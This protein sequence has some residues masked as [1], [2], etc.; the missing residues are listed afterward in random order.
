MPESLN[1]LQQ[2]IAILE[3]EYKTIRDETHAGHNTA[4]RIGKAFLDLLYLLEVYDGLFISKA[5]DD[6]THYEVRFLAGL[7][8]DM[9]VKSPDWRLGEWLKDPKGRDVNNGKGFDIWKNAVDMWNIEIDY[10]T[11]RQL[12][13]CRELYTQSAHIDE[14]TNQTLFKVGLQT[15][16]NIL[17]GYY[18]EGVQGGIITPDGHVEINTL[19]SRGLAK[20]QELFVVNDATFGGNL[21]SIEFISSFLGG[22]GWAIQKKKRIN[23]LGVEEEYY[24]LEIDNVTIRETLRVYELVVSQLRGEFDNYVFAAMMEVHHYDK[25]TGKVWLTTEGGRIKGVAFRK[26][27]YIKCQQYLP[28]N[29]VVSGGNGYITKSYELIVTNSGTG[30]ETDENGDRLDWITFKNFV[31]SMETEDGGTSEVE[32][33]AAIRTRTA[34]LLRNFDSEGISV[35][36]GSLTFDYLS[37][38]VYEASEQFSGNSAYGLPL[39]FKKSLFPNVIDPYGTDTNSR[40]FE[41]MAGWL[42]ASALTEIFPGKR[43]ELLKIGYNMGPDKG[44]YIYKYTFESDPNVGRLVASAICAAMRGLLKP[45]LSTMRSEQHAPA[46]NYKIST[47]RDAS[48][49]TYKD[50]YYVDLPQFMPTAPG[51]YLDRYANRAPV[52]GVPYNAYD[53]A[54]HNLQ[55]DVDVH[56]KVVSDYNLDNPAYRQATVQAIANKESTVNHVFG[57]NRSGGGYTFHPVFGADTIGKEI[58]T[59]GS[60][61][62]A[63]EKIG[64]IGSRSRSPLQDG[65][66]YGRKRPGQGD[67]DGSSPA[68]ASGVLVNLDIE[69]SDGTPTGYTDAAAWDRSQR[70]DVFANSYPSGHSSTTFAGALFLIETMPMRADLILKA[71]NQYATDRQITRYHWLSDT[72]IGRLS[73]AAIM[74]VVRGSSDYAS[75]LSDAR[76]EVGEADNTTVAVITTETDERTAEELIAKGD[77]FVRI[78]NETDPER[79]GLMQI[80]TVGPNTPY[81]DVYYGMKTNPN[82]ALKMRTGNLSGVRTDL[83]GWLEDFGAY[84]PNVYAV[85]KIFNRQTG[86]SLS[87]SIEITKERFKSVYSE[88]TYNINDDDNFLTNGFFA[89]DMEG[90]ERCNVNGSA[91][92]ADPAL[93]AIDSGN[94]T[95][96]MVNGAMLAYINRLTA[97]VTEYGGM[98]VLHLLGMAVCQDFDD[99]KDNET[100]TKSKSDNP[101]SDDYTNTEEVDNRLYMGVRILPISFGTLKVSFV[102]SNGSIIAEWSRTLN[103]GREWELVQSMDSE[104]TPWSYTGKSGRM[105]VSYTGECYIRFIALM[106]D[107]VVNS[108]E[109]YETKFEQTSRR[110]TLQAAKQTADLNSAVAEINIEFDNI[111]TTVTNNKDAADRAFANIISDLN[112]EIASREEL[113]GVYYA[114]WVYQNDRLLSLMAAQFNADGTIKGYADLKIQV[115]GISTTVT[116]NKS[117]ADKAFKTLTDN[118][119]AEIGSRESLENAYHATWV[120]Q[121]DRLLS[122]MAAQFNAD[123]TIKGYADLKIQVNEIS[124]TVT[125]NKKAAD[126]AFATLNNTTLPGIRSDIQSAYNLAD[127]AWDKADDAQDDIDTINATW[128]IQHSDRLELVSAQFD[129]NGKLTNTSGLVTGN[130]TFASL[131]SSAL[132]ADQTVAKVADITVFVDNYGTSNAAI[133]ADHI[134]FTTFDWTVKN[135]DTNEEIFHLDSEGNMTIAGKFHGEF[136]GT[137]VFGTGTKKM[138]IEPTRTGARL[139]GKDGNTEMLTLGFY[140]YNGDYVPSLYLKTPA[141][142]GHYQDSVFWA[143]TCEDV[144]QVVLESAGTTGA[145]KTLELVASARGGYSSLHSYFWPKKSDTSIYNSLSNGTLYVEDGYVKVKG[146]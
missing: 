62:A 123:G 12:L 75:M 78:D 18:A 1:T 77:T 107:P 27:D 50:T 91:V 17:I 21:S 142:Q 129:K 7:I 6:E 113:E 141:P 66:Y 100:H 99:I 36:S 138:Y 82:D 104:G 90:W 144:V 13:R 80:I 114:T 110:I 38:L 84:L 96:L 69:N 86:E 101:Q 106:T 108:R 120:Y 52:G 49:D 118:L 119:N 67:T 83:F 68:T 115:N 31:T 88:I 124:S 40:A 137:V 48:F 19:I 130:G 23:A 60:V 46:F 117:A 24:T 146:Y 54:D 134:N 143:L 32:V 85:G 70:G 111:R 8:A 25:M 139:V 136:D 72:I 39:L 5:H 133:R 53:L 126:E 20:L 81:Q 26:G 127:R 87:S 2:K 105:I 92:S 65:D 112:D 71:A 131:F 64:K 34:T 51:P 35:S 22:K 29:D 28:G 94:G 98:K 132:N 97:E 93:E 79:K 15:L 56:R 4:A 128:V 122:L 44:T 109:T 135:P 11:V 3:Q 73:G 116:D 10:A 33:P 30:G 41:C 140:Y 76:S 47:V 42:L 58:S 121:N 43:N 45:N 145:Y 74:P 103:A 9:F 89:R 95:P 59:S 102:Q 61:A 37:A 125:N 55:P 57:A 16:G 63:Y 14:V